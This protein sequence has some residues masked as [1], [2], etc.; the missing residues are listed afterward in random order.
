MAVVLAGCCFSFS[1]LPEPRERDKKAKSQDGKVLLRPEKGALLPSI[2]IFP[3]IRSFAVYPPF[4]VAFCS[5]LPLCTHSTPSPPFL[6]FETA[7]NLF[8]LAG[9]F[10]EIKKSTNETGLL[11]Q[12]LGYFWFFFILVLAEKCTGA[13][14]C[15]K[16]P[17]L[18][19]LWL[20]CVNSEC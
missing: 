10:P 12:R 4:S 7:S 3:P 8:N 13:H 9:A 17:P 20:M 15:R 6:A 11:R 18:T 14:E 5:N 2:G 1:P 16:P 19:Q